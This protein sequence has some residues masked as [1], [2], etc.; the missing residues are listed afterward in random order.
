MTPRN[1]YY[2]RRG[3]SSH[4]GEIICLGNIGM[5]PSVLAQSGLKTTVC[6]RNTS[7]ECTYMHIHNLSKSATMPASFYKIRIFR[8]SHTLS[9]FVKVAT[10]LQLVHTS[11]P[12]RH[13][14][15]PRTTYVILNIIHWKH[16][17]ATY[18]FW[19]LFFLLTFIP[20]GTCSFGSFT[21][22]VLILC[23]IWR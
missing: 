3:H 13:E 23:P 20:M 21:S 4:K 19:S 22:T 8:S 5:K 10:V 12:C 1:I 9:S 15:L 11:F 14:D 16:N 17:S 2:W 6:P 7:Y 18:V